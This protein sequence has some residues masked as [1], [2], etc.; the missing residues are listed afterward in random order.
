MTE[1]NSDT[2]SL[3]QVLV[4]KGTLPSFDLPL[5]VAV[6]EAQRI[7]KKSFSVISDHSVPKS[8]SSALNTWTPNRKHVI[9]KT[10]YKISGILVPYVDKFES[11]DI[12]ETRQINAERRK[13]RFA[14][15]LSEPGNRKYIHVC[16]ECRHVLE[17]DLI[18]TYLDTYQRGILSGE[19]PCPTCDNK[20]INPERYP[21]GTTFISLQWIQPPGYGPAMDDSGR[22][23]MKKSGGYS[24]SNRSGFGQRTI[25]PIQ[26]SEDD[27]ETPLTTENG[28]KITS[29]KEVS[30]LRQIVGRDIIP[31]Q[32]NP[33]EPVSSTTGFSICESCG[34]FNPNGSHSR[35][36]PFGKEL[37]HD[38]TIIYSNNERKQCSG[39]PI[40]LLLGRSF[41]S[42]ILSLKI[43]LGEFLIDPIASGDSR[44]FKNL[45]NAGF[46]LG[47]VLIDELCQKNSFNIDE[48]DCDVRIS[49]EQGSD[50]EKIRYLE[51]FFFENTSGGSGNLPHI[52]KSLLNLLNPK[53]SS[54]TKSIEDR[55]S[56]KKCLIMVPD[57]KKN[58]RYSSAQH[59]CN[60]AC[61][62]CLLD[63][64]NSNFAHR[65][66][67]ELSWHLWRFIK[68]GCSDFDDKSLF[69]HEQYL[70]KIKNYIENKSITEHLQITPNRVNDKIISAEIQNQD[71]DENITVQIISPLRNTPPA[72]N[73]LFSF[74]SD[75]I[76]FTLDDILNQ[77]VDELD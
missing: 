68:Y 76:K 22:K 13:D 17:S 58:G 53:S 74:S 18:E 67:R 16:V 43:P 52:H 27:T 37:Y 75:D 9:E 1:G 57:E 36:Y 51:I 56:G 33:D 60:K 6:F 15:W 7:S 40:S 5:D 72:E 34:I 24:S 65:L 26:Y 29:S 19:S 14:W 77:I 69:N 31:D 63:Y 8:L 2:R 73:G 38:T 48:F 28:I 49:G 70:I 23:P 41:T 45:E 50:T 10:D 30:K 46:T 59:P 4:D 71:N 25:W 35:P 32:Y 39:S 21:S 42:T 12:Q 66:D 47:R 3:I 55:L 20:E 11:N 61:N 44:S 54:E 62:G 64:R